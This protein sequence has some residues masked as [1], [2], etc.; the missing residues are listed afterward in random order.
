M[1][2][3]KKL[4]TPVKEKIEIYKK[5][6]KA[7]KNLTSLEWVVQ[8]YKK[9]IKDN[10][11]KLTFKMKN[12][13]NKN[14]KILLW[15]DYIYFKD[16]FDEKIKID[17]IHSSRLKENHNFKLLK[18]KFKKRKKQILKSPNITEK[19]NFE[20]SIKVSLYF[21][22]IGNIKLDNEYK[23]AINQWKFKRFKRKIYKL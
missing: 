8:D 9:E 18:E 3:V 15:N 19:N 6:I 14:L 22:D 17:Y 7:L 21:N 13:Y 1:L 2:F 10:D 12:N 11:L 16:E 4:E 23:N 5:S 20:N